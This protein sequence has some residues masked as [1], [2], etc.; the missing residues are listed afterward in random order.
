MGAPV[1]YG[2]CLITGVVAGVAWYFAALALTPVIAS[3]LAHQ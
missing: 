1:R 3:I 2:L